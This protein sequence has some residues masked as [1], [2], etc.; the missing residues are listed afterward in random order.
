MNRFIR[1]RLDHKKETT[2]DYLELISLLIAEKGEARAV[3]LANLLGISQVSVGK[4]LQKLQKEELVTAQTYRSIFLTEK[5]SNIA[6][7]AKKRH[8]LVVE[9]LISIGVPHQVAEEDAE[10]IE[11]H[12]SQAT[13]ECMERFVRK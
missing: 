6:Q 10:G 9:F 8:E 1:T 7:K 4:T 5:G 13:L 11:H 12:V 2:E 3:D